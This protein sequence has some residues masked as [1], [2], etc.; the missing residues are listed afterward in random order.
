MADIK[1]I[2]FDWDGTLSDSA[3]RI[4]DAVHVGAKLVGLPE[5]S[6]QDIRNIIGLGLM[7]SFRELYSADNEVLFEPFA[8]AYRDAYTNTG[9]Q[10]ALFPNV[11]AT[12]DVLRDR[13]TLAVATG[14]SRVG[15]DREL[16]ETNLGEYFIATRCA[17]ETKPKPDPL[18][19]RQ[20]LEVSGIAAENTLMIG[21]TDHDIHTAKNA[22]CLPIAVT[23]GAQ[24]L[25]RLE[26]AEP[27]A[28]LDT[29][30][31]L[32]RWLGENL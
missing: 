14:K 2:V 11:L 26:V 5:R 23:C 3:Q 30:A 13:F 4:V 32:P 27:A 1:L 29:V 6:N 10:A 19:L 17:D 16:Q 8:D 25:P 21:D 18:M 7:E 15:L 24:L 20:I 28:I 9:I 31:D 22:G 12:L